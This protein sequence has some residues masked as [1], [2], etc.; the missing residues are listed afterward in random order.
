MKST[1]AFAF[2]A[3]PSLLALTAAE[4][5]NQSGERGSLGGSDLGLEA[6]ESQI[7]INKNIAVSI[8]H[9]PLRFYGELKIDSRYVTVDLES[10][11]IINEAEIVRGPADLGCFLS[12]GKQATEAFYTDY[13]LTNPRTP[14][15]ASSVTCFY[16][17]SSWKSIAVWLSEESSSTAANSSPETGTRLLLIHTAHIAGRRTFERAITVQSAMLMERPNSRAHC[18]L[19][20]GNKIEPFGIDTPVS[21]PMSRVDE[22]FCFTT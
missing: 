12:N 4:P 21:T 8:P 14:V 20:S 9:A 6:E 2:V 18:E 3:F 19:R 10:P 11:V 13:P 7:L 1:L 15:E 17:P 5:S 22:V 16:L